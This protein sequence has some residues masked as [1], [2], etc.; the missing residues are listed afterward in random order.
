MKKIL[1]ISRQIKRF[2]ILFA[3]GLIITNINL[4]AQDFMTVPSASKIQRLKKSKTYLVLENQLISEFNIE[5]KAAMQQH[6]YMTDFEVISAPDF[7]EFAKNKTNSFIYLNPVVLEKDKTETA[8]LYCFLSLGH[9]SGKPHQL[10]DL[11]SI[12]LA[13]KGTEAE[14]Y[15]YK[16]GLILKFMQ[17]YIETVDKLSNPTSK[18]ILDYF[19]SQNIN[20][21][22]YE[23]WV[24]TDEVEASL[25]TKAGFS[26]FYPYP[27]KF[28]DENEIRTAIT[29][30]RKN[31][32]VLHLI[33][34]GENRY[35][36][37]LIADASNGNL[38]YYDYHKTS[39]KTA[40]LLLEK[41]LKNLSK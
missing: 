21:Q 12:P 31:T 28:A 24:K 23:L 10:S 37:K 26:S 3:I 13:I 1:F 35:C 33:K 34:A 32:L 9:P 22:D 27:F 20:L 40:S 29:E 15:S 18:S 16:Y 7:R 19:T 17:N 36:L 5:M 14:N 25:R 38:L 39:K 41:D 6:W 4:S 30:N 2:T 8:Y 11:I